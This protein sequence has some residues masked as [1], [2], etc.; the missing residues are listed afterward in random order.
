MYTH[1]WH[2]LYARSS[3]HAGALF[4]GELQLKR[5]PRIDEELA[6]EEAAALTGAGVAPAPV[7]LQRCPFAPC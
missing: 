2:A 5:R 6:K 3:L 4:P 1:A 7:L